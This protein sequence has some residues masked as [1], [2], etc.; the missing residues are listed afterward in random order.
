[1]DMPLWRWSATQLASA[2]R[3]KEITSREAVTACLD[4]IASINPEL[5]AVVSVQA[6]DALAAADL[7]DHMVA[8]GTTLGPL[9]GVPVTTKINVDQAGLPTTN[10]I[11]AFKDNIAKD[12]APVVANLRRAGAVIIG[13]TNTPA[14]SMRWFTDNELHGRTLNPWRP[15]R[16]PGGSSGGAAVAAATGMC[17][18]AH[19]NDGGGSIRYPAYCTGTVGLRPSFGRV[20][21][22]NGTAPSERQ[23]SL[24]LISVQGAITRNVADARLALAAMAA[25]DPRDPWHVAMPLEGPRRDHPGVAV[26]LDPAGVGIAPEV[27]AAVR[28]AAAILHRAGYEVS[29]RDPPDVAAAAKAWNDFAQG[30]ARLTLSAQIEQHGDAL[31]RRA[32]A[33]MMART[34]DLDVPSLMQLSAARATY[35]R[36][37]QAFMQEHP[38]VLCP[39]AME[40]ALPYGVDIESEASVDRLYRSHVFLFATAY[41]GLPSISVPTGVH[42]GIPIGVQIVGPRFREDLV[43]DAAAAVEHAAAEAP[44]LL[45]S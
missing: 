5:N 40:T 42:E 31:A 3:N 14:F 32:F 19:G 27:E 29:W 25:P 7:A 34:P 44:P 45:S 20:P 9:H 13:R 12:D 43:L 36:R 35:L 8:A 2:I 16:T 22:F 17:A 30:E 6:D 24:Q 26:C 39:V 28:K 11:V 1:M 21:A 10:G 33:L 41:L 18:I 15:D 4:R 38:L 37:W 23:L